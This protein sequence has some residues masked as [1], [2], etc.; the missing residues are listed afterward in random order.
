MN[1]NEPYNICKR[2]D[3]SEGSYVKLDLNEFDFVHHPS[4][5]QALA[6]SVKTRCAVTTR[7]SN[8]YGRNHTDLVQLI[9]DEEGISTENVMLTAGSDEGLGY[10]VKAFVDSNSRAFV[11]VPSYNYCEL[12]LRRTTRHV[13]DIPLG[14]DVGSGTFPIEDC[15]NFY[16]DEL[17]GGIVY[18]VNPN[19]PL[20]TLLEPD[21][22]RRTVAT[23]ADTMFIVDEAY[24]EYCKHKTIAQTAATLP[25]V[26]VTRTF[27]KAYGLAGLR[28]GY[29]IASRETMATLNVQ[30]N[31]KNVTESA[32]IA[33]SCV[34]R[35]IGHYAQICD[36]TIVQRT[37]FETFLDSEG[38][39]F[40][41]SH[42]NF[43][44]FFV[45]TRLR[46][47]LQHLEAGGI[48]IRDRDV[49]ANMTGFAR[50]TIGAR[51]SMTALMRALSDNL[52]M[53]ESRCVVKHFTQKQHVWKLLTLFKTLNAVLDTSALKG[54][55]WMDSGT[56]L[57]VYRNNGMI[58]WDDDIDIAMM[59]SDAARLELLQGELRERGVR[60]KRNRTDCYYQVD[61]V[62]DVDPLNEQKT[63]D[64]H[65]DIFMFDV[66][67]ETLV[68]TDPR[69]R[70]S[71]GVRC[72]L[73]YTM[74]TVFP[75]QNSSF[76]GVPCCIP[77]KAEQLLETSFKKEALKSAG[78]MVL[79]GEVI[80][81]DASMFTY[82]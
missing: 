67:G 48:Y 29:I 45:G 19:N 72:N 70:R 4:V 42:A 36:E 43:V 50:A 9:A 64:V 16:K 12:L 51:D 49:Q 82:A 8:V 81:V 41:K 68:N 58:P 22:L 79:G 76:Y 52:D 20:G 46:E 80:S 38:V 40:I 3:A 53:F 65:V 66:V 34:M 1:I 32:K 47:L 75:L 62:A 26:I 21:V 11:F 63:C 73:P 6:E 27:S 55:Y 54:A 15:L 5:H 7:Y 17:R 30:Y 14:L 31:Q 57:G 44:S 28:L 35:N 71:H 24:I 18:I 2:M 39:Y 69:F 23:H 56:L 78:V 25:N 59:S 74:D 60:L 61:F 10:I 13:T 33:G 37:R 77:N